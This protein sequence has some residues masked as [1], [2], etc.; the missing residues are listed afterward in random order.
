MKQR[1]FS[2]REVISSGERRLVVGGGG[3]NGGGKGGD[4]VFEFGVRG[5]GAAV[6]VRGK[7]EDEG[8][9]GVVVT[10]E[11]RGRDA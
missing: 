5:C 10:G 6:W 1:P 4:R 11:G 2:R 8:N 7:E 9:V 3:C